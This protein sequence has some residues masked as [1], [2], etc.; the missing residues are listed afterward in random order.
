MVGSEQ[1]PEALVAA[2][3]VIDAELVGSVRP[4]EAKVVEVAVRFQPAPDPVS[5]LGESASGVV[6]D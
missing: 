1:L 3:A 5:S 6:I 4:L 2:A